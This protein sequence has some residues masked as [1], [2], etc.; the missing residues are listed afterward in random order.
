M[1]LVAEATD[2]ALY[3]YTESEDIHNLVEPTRNG[4]KLT[5]DDLKNDCQLS[6]GQYVVADIAESPARTVEKIHEE[7]CEK[8]RKKA[9]EWLDADYLADIFGA[10]DIGSDIRQDN[11]LKVL[12]K[13]VKAAGDLMFFLDGSEN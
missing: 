11:E 5:L 8:L 4:D 2:G 1:K 13:A 10:T 12:A 7:L 3:V 6:E 9:I